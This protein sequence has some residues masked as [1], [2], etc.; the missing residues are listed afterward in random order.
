MVLRESVNSRSLIRVIIL[1][2][3][4]ALLSCTTVARSNSNRLIKFYMIDAHKKMLIRNKSDFMDFNKAHGMFC[5]DRQGLMELG[6]GIQIYHQQA[7]DN[8]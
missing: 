7:E 8:K 5:T 1:V 2:L 6:E 3:F 4:S